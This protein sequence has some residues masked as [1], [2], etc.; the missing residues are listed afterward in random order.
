MTFVRFAVLVLVSL[1]G[2][3]ACKRKPAAHGPNEPP[4]FVEPLLG[5]VLVQR[6]DGEAKPLPAGV[7]FDD[8]AMTAAARTQLQTANIFA[9]ASDDPAVEL[10]PKANVLVGYSIENVWHSGQGVAQA[11]VKLRVGIKPHQL[12]DPS[13]AED[14]EAS[15]EIPY[16][17]ATANEA[18]A[19]A[20]STLVPRM[21]TDMLAEYISR[22]SLRRASESELVRVITQGAGA[23]LEDAIRIAGQRQVKAAIDSLLK[24]LND[25]E[26]NIRDAA[27]GA[28]VTLRE[29]R[30]VSVLAESRSMR[31][32]REMRKILTA[33][34][35]L[36]GPEAVDYL[37]FVADGH[38]DAEIRALAKESLRRAER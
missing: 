33:L 20:F 23:Q 13:W 16:Q 32:T 19:R 31:D 9:K 22:Q 35:L 10:P 2:L 5:E 15:G 26:E 11:Q 7:A 3:P 8:A 36:G 1:C 38:D 34:S 29:P 14:V 25:E 18:P 6:M 37:K 17:A 12:A 24:R 4:A 21:V 27:L 28:L 30:A